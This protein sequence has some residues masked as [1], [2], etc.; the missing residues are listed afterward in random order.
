[1]P[2]HRTFQGCT[3]NKL[4]LLH[5]I[6]VVKGTLYLIPVTL[7][8]IEFEHVIPTGVIEIAKKIRSFIVED[9]R[10]ARRFLRS[11]DRKFPID[12]SEFLVLNE[13]TRPA[14]YDSLLAS[15]MDGKDTGLMSEAGVPGI[16]DPGSPV[17]SLAHKHG[18][19]VVPLTGPSSIILSLMASG[20]NGQS[21]TFHGYIPIKQPA[22]TDKIK[23]I[24]AK[25]AGGESQILIETP[26]RNQKLIEDILRVCRP[27]T[28]VCIAVDITGSNE[29]I[30]TKSVSD[31]RKNRP[32]LDKLP[33]IFII[34]R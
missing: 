20:L 26:Y 25:A 14:E 4:L 6:I 27:E 10:S 5:E 24:E 2:I 18:I 16:A 32:V 8:T 13:H 34:G 22:R 23:L 29:S 11:I 28:E 7:G 31:W 9:V 12:S 19:R 30:V 15:L 21:F 17:V 3:I 1:M 33:A